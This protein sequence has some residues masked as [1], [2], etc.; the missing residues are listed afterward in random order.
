M[1]PFLII[2]VPLQTTLT[3]K[4][5]LPRNKEQCEQYKHKTHSVT[6]KNFQLYHVL[7]RQHTPDVKR[8]G[9]PSSL[10]KIHKMCEQRSTV[11]NFA[12]LDAQVK[13]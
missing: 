5:C 7:L 3:N 11:S 9:R 13:G 4:L 2:L 8:A 1:H 10:V 12:A 6:L